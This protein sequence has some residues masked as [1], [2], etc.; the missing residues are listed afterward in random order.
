L[1]LSFGSHFKNTNKN[2]ISTLPFQHFSEENSP[3]FKKVRTFSR[4][5]TL[6]V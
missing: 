2:T 4:R 3:M 6:S 1:I 5:K